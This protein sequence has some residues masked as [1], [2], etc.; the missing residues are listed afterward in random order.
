LSR[1]VNRERPWTDKLAVYDFRTNQY[2]T[3]RANPMRFEHLQDFIASYNPVNRHERPETKRFR[4]FTYNDLMQRDKV[5]L[6]IVWLKDDSLEDTENLPE[7]DVM[8]REIA[9]N[10]QATLDQFSGIYE[11]LRADAA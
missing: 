5:S 2:F 11:D 6:D 9:D 10:P 8:T 1:A 4:A 3:L 7:P